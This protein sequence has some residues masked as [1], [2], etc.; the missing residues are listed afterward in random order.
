MFCLSK[1]TKTRALNSSPNQQKQS[2]T[3]KIPVHTKR[4]GCDKK[5]KRELWAK[6]IIA[7][8]FTQ[9]SIVEEHKKASKHV[10]KTVIFI[11]F[12]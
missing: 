1:N 4:N 7:G 6:F 8:K 2:P 12:S 11:L 5:K 3:T 10:D 9:A